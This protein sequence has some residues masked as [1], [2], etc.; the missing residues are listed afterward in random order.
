ME[1]SGAE[2]LMTLTLETVYEEEVVQIKL[3]KEAAVLQLSFLQH[4]ASEQ[5]R[6]AYRL[7]IDLAQMKGVRYWLTDAQRIKSMLPE[8]QAWLVQ[9]M[10]PLFSSQQ[11]KKFA[12]VM[13][14]E[15]FVMT[16]PTKVY[17][18]P[19]APEAPSAKPIKVHFDKDAAYQWLLED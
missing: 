5:F 15:C 8:N 3:S 10:A 1:L 16:N 6:N 12:I 4:P 13:A 14:P 11:L 19:V 18:K 2:K 7:A 9:N 17:E